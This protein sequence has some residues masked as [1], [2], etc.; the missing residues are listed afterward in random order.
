PLELVGLD[1]LGVRPAAL[2]VRRSVDSR[3]G[4]AVEREVVG[5]V[6]LEEAAVAGFVGLVAVASDLQT[7]R[8]RVTPNPRAARTRGALGTRRRAPRARRPRTARATPPVGAGSR[9]T[10][11]PPP[12]GSSRAPRPRSG[13][14]APACPPRPRPAPR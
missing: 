4:R 12:R 10:R 2:E 8:H 3:V 1:Q 7:V 13:G 5:Q 14:P 6:L 9:R 11:R